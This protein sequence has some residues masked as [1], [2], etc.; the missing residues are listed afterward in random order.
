MF[1]GATRAA[2]ANAVMLRAVTDLAPVAGPKQTQISPPSVKSRESE[3]AND[4]AVPEP[5]G[6][7]MAD[8]G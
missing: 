3:Y 6:D 5:S 4:A 7:R 1:A 8:A 2:R